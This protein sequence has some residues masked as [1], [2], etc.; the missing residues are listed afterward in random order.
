VRTQ[1]RPDARATLAPEKLVAR[2]AWSLLRSW[3]PGTPAVVETRLKRLRDYGELLLRW[4]QGVSNLISRND[5]IRLVDRHI[6]ESIEPAKLLIESGCKVFVDFGSGA[7]L[8]AIPLLFLGVGDRWTLV[9]SRRNKTLFLRRVE[10]DFK[11]EHFTA[12]TARLEVI[13]ETEHDD[14]VCDGFTSR[15]TMLMSPTLEMAATIVRSGGKAFLW[16]GSSWSEEMEKGR[17]LW[18]PQWDFEQAFPVGD[19]PNVVAV[20]IRK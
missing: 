3:I 7:G 13:I 1:R 15:A 10:Q 4:N 2:Q 19:G 8:P 6:R 12:K 17:G 20:F 5:E 9:E 14:L 18:E 16:K 11:L